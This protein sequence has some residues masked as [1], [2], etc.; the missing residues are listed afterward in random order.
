[1]N[2]TAASYLTRYGVGKT[3]EKY[4]TEMMKCTKFS[5]NM[6]ESTSNNFHR[7]LTIL[8]SFY[9]PVMRQVKVCHFGSLSCFKVEGATLYEKNVQLME[10]NEISL[11][12]YDVNFDGFMQCDEGVKDRIRNSYT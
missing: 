2:R 9:R 4:V 8:V 7:V 10:K 11:G 5:L 6:D 12:Q 1:M 3:F